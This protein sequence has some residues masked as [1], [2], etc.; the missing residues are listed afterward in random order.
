MVCSEVGPPKV[1]SMAFFCAGRFFV[2]EEEEERR[3]DP[4]QRQP[5][6]APS[7]PQPPSL[8]DGRLQV[9]MDVAVSNGITPTIDVFEDPTSPQYRPRLPTSRSN[10]PDVERK[11]LVR[12]PI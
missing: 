6:T 10:M 9:F 11:A 5:P 1:T 4:P 8:A 7:G 12:L 2:P 3:I